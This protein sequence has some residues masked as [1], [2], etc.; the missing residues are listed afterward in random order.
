[1]E[2]Y[3]LHDDPHE[4]RNLADDAQFGEVKKELMEQLIRWRKDTDD[5]YLDPDRLEADRKKYL[6]V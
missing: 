4:W 1:V 5:P 3:D 2:L 6:G